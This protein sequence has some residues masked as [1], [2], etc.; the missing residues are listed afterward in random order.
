MYY[1]GKLLFIDWPDLEIFEISRVTF[2]IP[3]VT[4]HLPRVN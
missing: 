4:F 1:L 3:R 2:R